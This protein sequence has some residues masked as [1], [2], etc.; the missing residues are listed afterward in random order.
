LYPYGFA[1]Y[2]GEALD[3]KT[4]YLDLYNPLIKQLLQSVH[5]D[6]T[7]QD[8]CKPVGM[9]ARI[10]LIDSALTSSRPDLIFLDA[11]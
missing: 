11:S 2:T 10:L 4:Y 6:K 5:F 3:L 1:A 9:G 8:H 7:K